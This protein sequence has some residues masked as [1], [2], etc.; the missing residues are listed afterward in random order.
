MQDFSWRA[1]QEQPPSRLWV[2]G[3]LTPIVGLA[4]GIFAAVLI[5]S[6]P[7]ERMSPHHA[8]LA[9]PPQ[10]S[11]QFPTFSP[12]KPSPADKEIPNLGPTPTTVKTPVPNSVEPATPRSVTSENGVSLDQGSPPK[13][14]PLIILNAPPVSRPALPNP[15]AEGVVCSPEAIPG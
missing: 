11:G 12:V 6:A 15:T 14:M 10:P 13:E 3:V 8:M 7:T 1:E 5:T 2:Y 4:I 9:Q